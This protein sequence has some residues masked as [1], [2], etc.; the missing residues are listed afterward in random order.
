MILWFDLVQLSTTKLCMP[1][2]PSS[3]LLWKARLQVRQPNHTSAEQ[4]WPA[5]GCLIALAF[6]KS[7]VKCVS[8]N[9]NVCLG[10][11]LA[12]D[13]IR[14]IALWGHASWDELGMMHEERLPMSGFQCRGPVRHFPLPLPG[15]WDCYSAIKSLIAL[16]KLDLS[17]SV[18]ACNQTSPFNLNALT[19]K[20]YF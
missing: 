14:K 12:D 1:R 4:R 7:D 19:P 15:P 8:L 11:H 3:V 17:G 16:L 13:N 5:M 9:S 6:S 2:W 18:K 20:P 10:S